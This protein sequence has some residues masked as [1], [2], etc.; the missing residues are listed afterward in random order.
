[1]AHRARRARLAAW[2]PWIAV[3]LLAA[4]LLVA[5]GY[6]SADADTRLHTLLASHLASLPLSHWIAPEWWG[7]KG[8]QGDGQ[9]LY[10]EHPIGIL[11]L[12]ALLEKL[13]YPAAQAPLLVNAIYEILTLVLLQRLAAFLV[14]PLESRALL[15]QIQLIPVAFTFR[16]RANHEQAVLLFLVAALL[17]TELSRTSAWAIALTVFGVVATLLVKG[18]FAI[19]A[20]LFCAVWLWTVRRRE[21]GPGSDATA[22][23]GL[24]IAAAVGLAV[25]LGYEYAYRHVTGQSFVD[26]YFT[27]QFAR[28]AEPQ[29]PWHVFHKLYNFVWYAARVLAFASP[30]SVAAAIA[31]WRYRRDFVRVLERKPLAASDPRDARARQGLVFAAGVTLLYLLFFSM[32]DRDSIRYIFPSY[33]L[34]AACGFVVLMRVWTPLRSFAERLD[35][36][37]P[38]VPAA[39][40][41]ATLL[42][43]VAAFLL[44]VP[45]FKMWSPPG[46]F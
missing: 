19:P 1:M 29:S 31:A 12:P 26:Y 44:H 37:G 24:G 20:L 36:H 7:W 10:R 40:W 30:V 11:I 23:L 43:G 4:V 5:V 35:R 28:A 25:A 8:W 34:F 45:R 38:I 21:A 17:G 18:V 14:T 9:G 16:I 39:V 46:S 15:W 33:Y 2:S 6:N 22:W 3:I 27:S 42:L 32:S 13:G 41:L